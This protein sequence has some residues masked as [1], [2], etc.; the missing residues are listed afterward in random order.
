MA[1]SA[2][3]PATPD[4]D[5]IPTLLRRVRAELSAEFV[6]SRPIRVSRAPGRL[7]VMGGIADYTGSLVCEMPLDRAAAVALQERDDR[8]LRLF[9]FNLLDQRKPFTFRIPLDALA[10]RPP[11]ALRREFGEAGQKWAG[12][13]AGCLAVLHGQRYVDLLDPGFRAMS[14]AVYSTVPMGAGVSSSAAIEVAAMMNLI[15]HLGLR[16]RVG[17]MQL[18]ELC[19]SVE[20]QIVGAPCGIMD[21][22]TSCLG[23]SGSLLRMVCQPHELQEPLPLPEGVRVIGINSN[24]KHDVGGPAYARTR[25]AAFMGHKIILEKMREMGAALGRELIADP[26]QGYL[27][28]LDPD[29]Y[30]N[31]FRPAM[32]EWMGGKAFLDRFGPTIDPVTQVD[33]DERYPIRHAADHHVLEA[34]RVRRFVEFLEQARAQQAE[35]RRRA[36]DRAGHLMY[37]SHQSYTQDA[38]LGAAECDLLVSLVRERE[39]AGLYGARITG[40]GSGGTVAVLCDRNQGADSA[41]DEIL[42]EYQQRTGRRPEALSG[43]SAGAWQFGTALV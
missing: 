20:N 15:D 42:R 32:P 8:E 19:Q 26:M 23:E 35:P 2:P 12:Y 3:T 25:C 36:L 24:V 38:M 31:F 10:T 33:P 18:A 22:V 43:T 6:P 30:K 21:Q 14:L 13:L 27:A 34:R 5:P 29:D 1:A 11:D 37:G 16:D 39:Y 9:T 17:P 7:D 4:A 28:N 40:G 41:I